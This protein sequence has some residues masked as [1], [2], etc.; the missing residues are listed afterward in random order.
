MVGLSFALLTHISPIGVAESFLLATTWVCVCVCVCVCVRACVRVF[1]CACACG[2]THS[3]Q[4]TREGT[5]VDAEAV[6]RTFRGL[7]YKIRRED[8]QTVGEMEE[9]LHSGTGR[10]YAAFKLTQSSEL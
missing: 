7:G 8:D 4:T 6:E 9:L 10:R 1:V 3:G 2:P 5:N